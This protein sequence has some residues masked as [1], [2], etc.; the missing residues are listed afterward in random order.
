MNR[1]L[2]RIVFCSL[3]FLTLLLGWGYGTRAE[4]INTYDNF[5]SGVI[6]PGKWMVPQ[7]QTFLSVIPTPSTVTPNSYLSSYVLH[8]QGHG[9]AAQM[10]VSIQTVSGSSFQGGFAAGINYYNFSYTGPSPQATDQKFPSVSL[11]IGNWVPNHPELSFAYVLSRAFSY[12]SPTSPPEDVLAWKKVDGMGNTLWENGIQQRGTMPYS[13]DS[14]GLI[15]V[16]EPFRNG[17]TLSLGYA[18]S[19][20]PGVWGPDTFIPIHDAF[21]GVQFSNGYGPLLRIGVNGGSQTD[22]WMTADVGGLYYKALD[23]QAVPIPGAL[24]LLGPG[25]VGLA[26]IRRRFKK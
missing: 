2:T 14:G 23:Q 19:A 4:A 5:S 6:D 26:A 25:L 15:V 3:A 20:D 12:A 7:G 1:R 10:G 16:Y 13:A 11:Q 18:E 8:A 22:G 17:G 9:N 24:W 21:T